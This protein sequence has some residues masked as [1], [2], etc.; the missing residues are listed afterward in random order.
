MGSTH[1]TG[2]TTPEHEVLIIGTGF[3]GLCM[4]IQLKKAGFHSFTMLEKEADLG[5]TWYVNTYPGCACDVNSHMYSFSFEPNPNWSREFASQPEI[6]QYVRHCADKYELRPRIQ[7]KTQAVSARFDEAANVWRVTVANADDVAQFMGAHGLKPGDALQ[8]NAADFPKTREITARVVVAGMGG[9]STPAYPRLSGLEGFKGRTFH[10]QRWDH[11]YDLGGK[12]VA[13]VGTGASA[14]QFVPAIQAQVGHMDVYQRTPAW[15]MP[16]PNPKISEQKRRLYRTLP[17]TRMAERLR[18]YALLESRAI[19]FTI[20]PKLAKQAERFALSYLKRRVADPVLREK[21]TPKYAMGCKRVLLSS[22]WYGAVSAPNVDL[23][24]SGI[25]EVREHSIVD[26]QGVERPVDCIIYGTGFR[27]T[28]LIPAGTI[29]GR[30]GQDLIDAWPNGPEAYKGTAVSGFPN[31]YILVGPNTG[32]G[33]NSIIYM[34]EAQVHYVMEALKH[35]REKDL[36][37]LEVRSDVQAKFNEDLQKKSKN[38]VWETGGCKSYYLHPES[39][40]N[41]AVWPDFTFRFAQITRTFDASNYL[42]TRVP[43]TRDAAE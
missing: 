6:L 13:V 24:T 14:I 25:R 34:I 39:G 12:R 21:L 1:T 35:M 18:L 11:S 19:A 41:V 38:T 43:A 17:V 42:R 22:E 8:T 27:L 33:H 2:A 37:A 10:S 7:L 15:I 36:V 29:F 20:N 40:R 4:A 5:G 28:D 32:L 31:M 9:L 23:I 26:E 30:G 3:A 16:K